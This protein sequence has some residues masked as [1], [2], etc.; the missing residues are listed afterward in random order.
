VSLKPNWHY[1]GT[2]P[3]FELV[4]SNGYEGSEVNVGTN[5]DSQ[6][7]LGSLIIATWL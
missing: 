2:S 3:A 6:I 4:F 5:V 1:R 7:I